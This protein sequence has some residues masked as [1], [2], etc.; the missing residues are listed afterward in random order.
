MLKCDT[1]QTIQNR[2][3][4]DNSGSRPS[5]IATPVGL[6]LECNMKTKRCAKCKKV[7]SVDEFGKHKRDGYQSYCKKCNSKYSTEW[8]KSCNRQAYNK[9]IAQTPK[10][11]E[12]RRLYYLRPDV[13]QRKAESERLRYNTN[14][15][16]RAKAKIRA[17]TRRARDSGAILRHPCE[18]CGDKQS[19]MHHEDYF[20][21][22]EIIW[23]CRKCHIKHHAKAKEPK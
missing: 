18:K 2:L 8:N 23:L 1:R 6:L 7:K 22:L 4:G 11:V 13:K 3:T 10:C 9:A 16:Y 17:A 15:E 20:K 19:Q 21:P 5:C 14:P 12:S